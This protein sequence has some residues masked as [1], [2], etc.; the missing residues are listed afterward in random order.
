M[1]EVFRVE[2]DWDANGASTLRLIE[3]SHDPHGE[4]PNEYIDEQ[5]WGEYA[6]I[7]VRWPC[8]F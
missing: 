8:Q 3:T 7:N 6:I 4:D 2:R 5:E 1:L